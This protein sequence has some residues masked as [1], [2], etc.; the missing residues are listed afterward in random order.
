[1]MKT[2]RKGVFA[3]V[4]ALVMSLAL[5][6]GF[7]LGSVSAETAK[8]TYTLS[9]DDKKSFSVYSPTWPN[10]ID[11]LDKANQL[12]LHSTVNPEGDGFSVPAGANAGFVQNN[13]FGTAGWGLNGLTLKFYLNADPGAGGQLRLYF[14]NNVG[15]YSASN[16]GF[17]LWLWGINT[18][19]GTANFAIQSKGDAGE[20]YASISDAADVPVNFDYDYFTDPAVKATDEA[21]QSAAPATGT[22]NTWRFYF[23]D[24]GKLMLECN[25]GSP[26]RTKT[27]DLSTSDKGVESPQDRLYDFSRLQAGETTNM[28]AWFADGLKGAMRIVEVTSDSEEPAQGV[29]PRGYSNA[30]DEPIYGAYSNLGFAK[31]GGVAANNYDY[32]VSYNTDVSLSKVS[33]D[34]LVRGDSLKANDTYTMTFDALDDLG[35]ATGNSVELAFKKPAADSSDKASLTVTGVKDGARTAI[36]TDQE[37][38]FVWTGI[39]GDGNLTRTYNNVL[40]QKPVDT[41]ELTVNGTAVAGV[42]A[43]IKAALGEEDVVSEMTL[44]VSG[45]AAS[46]LTVKRIV[47]TAIA[48]IDTPEGYVFE[49][50][51]TKRIKDLD[52]APMFYTTAD[53]AFEVGIEQR[54]AANSFTVN[55]SLD[56]LGAQTKPFRLVLSNA[57]AQEESF[58]TGDKYLII[59]ITYKTATTAD[60]KFIMSDNGTETVLKSAE[61]ASFK[62]GQSQENSVSFLKYDSG[63]ARLFVNRGTVINFGTDTVLNAYLADHFENGGFISVQSLGEAKSIFVARGV[64]EQVYMSEPAAG[65]KPGARNENAEF[66][67]GT[68]GSVGILHTSATSQMYSSEIGIGNFTVKFKTHKWQDGSMTFGLQDKSSNSDWFTLKDNIGLTF[69]LGKNRENDEIVPGKAVLKLTYNTAEPK[70]IVLLDGAVVD[71]QDDTYY[72]LTIRKEGANWI[73]K[74]NDVVITSDEVIEE[75]D[76]EAFDTSMEEIF[77]LFNQASKTGNGYFVNYTDETNAGFTSYFLTL[78]T[79][80]V[81]IDN[82]GSDSIQVGGTAQLSATVSPSMAI[83]TGKWST[84]D[85][86][87]A[88]VDQ[89]GLVTAVAV[90]DVTITFTADDGSKAT[91]DL[92]VTAKTPTNPDDEPEKTGCACGTTGWSGIAGIG[93]GMLILAG[94]GALMLRRRRV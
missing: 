65:W 47:S 10:E 80:T 68:D 70:D 44:S 60:I 28:V 40:L 55:L 35:V 36:V 3:L 62:W 81:S 26:E 64:S 17:A 14:V 66:V 46:E 15:W 12:I 42:D 6:A 73:V 43:G 7:G 54:L 11:G 49:K 23:D 19:N 94:I 25:A 59:E 9:A 50:S 88:T 51:D 52:G 79:G 75:F 84:S 92:M 48:E 18:E 61:G 74:I 53:E 45:S 22:L 34:F 21:G 56:K 85:A 33:T 32:A 8:K 86:S 71:W 82:S 69:N 77:A 20:A 4:A 1:M 27:I 37:V 29:T 24:E 31:F 67:Y 41:Y 16:A 89:N 58:A 30:S 90:G 63:A 5:F 38:S 76:Q 78:T 57:V 83:Q 91:Y 72:T 13:D 39:S 87:V 2:K 93:G